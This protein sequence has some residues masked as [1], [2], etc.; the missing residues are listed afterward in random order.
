[1]KCY[2]KTNNGVILV[3]VKPYSE[4]ATGKT[5]LGCILKVICIIKY[6]L[7]PFYFH[8]THF[9]NFLV[10]LKFF[11]VRNYMFKALFIIPKYFT[12]KVY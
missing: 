11:K 3:V 5:Y 6:I 2:A 1:M 4:K 10:K 12:A 8:Y 7:I 9:D